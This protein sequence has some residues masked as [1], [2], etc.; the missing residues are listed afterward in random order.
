MDQLIK[1][2]SYQTPITEQLKNSLE[3]EV[4]EDLLE[5]ISTI[6]FIDNLIKPENE[7][8][9][10][11]DLKTMQYVAGV[12]K[13]GNKVYKNYEDGRKEINIT[14][15]HMLEDMD[16]FRQAAI[17][18]DK[19]GKYTNLPINSNPKSEYAQF[20][21]EE[22]RRWKYGLVRPSDG[23]WIPGGLYFYWNYTPIWLTEKIG[24]SDSDKIESRRIRKFPKPW[25]GDYLFFHYL[26]QA[27]NNGN[28]AK[29]LKCRG[30]GMSFKLA[31]LSPRNIFVYPGSGNTNMHLASE[32]TFLTGDTGLWGKILDNL[33]WIAENT[34]L[35]RMR[36]VDRRQGVLELQLG[37]QD[38][39]GVRKGLLSSVSGVSLKDNPDKA[40]GARGVLVHYEEDGLFPGLEKAWN[41]NRK[42]MEDGNSVFGMMIAAGTGGVEGGSFI[43]SEKLFYKPKAYNIYSV[44]NVYDKNT[45]GNTQCGFFWGAYLNREN[46]YDENTGEPDVT[47]A[48]IEILQ[49]RYIVKYNSPDPNAITQKKAEEPLTPQEAV[50]RTTGTVFPVSD[51]KEY[52][53]SIKVKEQ[54]FVK[55][56]YVGDFIIDNNGQ[57][58]WKEDPMLTPLRRYKL[59][60]NDNKIGA[61]EIFEMPKRDSNGEV[62]KNRYIAG[63]D[64]IDADQGESLFS[65]LILDTF[66]DR[67]V[68]EY[69]GRPRLANTAYETAMRALIYY[70]ATANYEKNL[71]GL[72]AYFSN[73][74]KL[75]LLADTP[76]ILRDMDL[77]GNRELIG[78]NSKGS[79][80]TA[81]TNAWGRKLQADWLSSETETSRN[82]TEENKEIIL[83]LHKVRSLG[84]LEEAMYWNQ[85]GNFDRISAGNML[86]IYREEKLRQIKTAKDLQG[87]I[88]TKLANDKFF[89]NSWNKINSNSYGGILNNGNNRI[90]TVD[91]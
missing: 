34:P 86:F 76:Q 16:Y 25:L 17:T 58:Q 79:S 55:T 90:I 31:S 63:I 81:Q 70:S 49:D 61:C 91:N 21:K 28:H 87:A 57:V 35:P 8:G 4:W 30:I 1:T 78:N 67:I 32:K 53:E 9:F 43:G 13:Y 52:L 80:A 6:Q 82:N 15:P 29:C 56:H 45:N 66:T 3:K 38:K 33:D 24:T 83:N 73:K 85:D 12:D 84:Y 68:F 72:F 51:I 46:C 64:T 10:A 2:N 39:Y 62:I 88:V 37:Y 47:K 40:R 71:K 77:T 69:T 74:N 7:R 42:A 50:L 44:P 89:N 75:Y 11:K 59:E 22:L 36:L 41:V 20:W 23:E 48:L 26:E 65:I 18:F 27:K 14:K 5:S 54:L 60:G 19:T